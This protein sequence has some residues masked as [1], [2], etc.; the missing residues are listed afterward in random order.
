VAMSQT[1]HRAIAGST[2][3][4]IPNARHLTPLECPE[5]IVAELR[6]LMETVPAQ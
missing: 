1:L 2:M 6:K 3:T 4:V 5:T